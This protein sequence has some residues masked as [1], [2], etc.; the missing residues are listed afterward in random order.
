M[1]KNELDLELEKNADFKTP[2]SLGALNA[3]IDWVEAVEPN[4]EIYDQVSV[5]DLKLADLSHLDRA[6]EEFIGAILESLAG[7][8]ENISQSEME[9]NFDDTIKFLNSQ[10]LH[11]SI[12]DL[13]K[14]DEES[15]RNKIADHFASVDK[16]KPELLE[17]SAEVKADLKKAT[18]VLVKNIESYAS[19][20]GV[21]LGQAST[22]EAIASWI[23][24]TFFKKGSNAEKIDKDK[25]KLE[26]EQQIEFLHNINEL[27]NIPRTILD[28]QILYV[29]DKTGQSGTAKLKTAIE[30]SAGW[31]P[32][33]QSYLEDLSTDDTARNLVMADKML[34]SFKLINGGY[35]EK[36][37][38]EEDSMH[39]F[40]DKTT[41]FRTEVASGNYLKAGYMQTINVSKKKEQS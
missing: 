37:F 4:V 5:E 41:A 31:V 7:G 8:T 38:T 33:L 12:A 26:L 1:E 11:A 23:K 28:Q 9:K 16:L 21:I 15:L 25:L 13:L 27:G 19:K 36:P 24:G 30:Y 6:G 18:D 32:Y 40:K 35:G 29:D 14:L 20:S 22:P 3:E 39:Q 34:K 10:Y 17:P 2:E